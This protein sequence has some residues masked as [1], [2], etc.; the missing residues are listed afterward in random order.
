F[1]TDPADPKVLVNCGATGTPQTFIVS[2]V[3]NQAFQLTGLA[4]GKGSVSPYVVSGPTLPATLAIGASVTVTVTPNPIPAA[5]AQPNDPSPFTDA[6]TVTTNAALDTPHVI[7][8]VMQARGAILVDTPLATTW[9]FGTIG[10][11]GVGTFTSTVT[12]TG[13]ATAS[14]A[15]TGLAQPTIFGLENNPTI[16][17]A[18]DGTP[19]VT[20]VV[21]CFA[22]PSSN[23]QWSDQGTLA[24]T[25]TQ[26]FCAP[27]PAAWTS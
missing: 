21:G 27:L 18:S 4:L 7:A 19:V 3:G 26:A 11:G 8:L 13:N 15:L 25:A 12:N 10:G 2:N 6:L 24:V 20:L 9:S 1:G 23:G 14:I 17:A 22:P 5:V 16:V